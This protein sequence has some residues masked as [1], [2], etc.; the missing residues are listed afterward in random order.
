MGILE[1]TLAAAGLVLIVLLVIG[2]LTTKA[3]A[4]PTDDLAAPYRQGLH[5][6]IRMQVVAQ[7]LEQQLYSQAAQHLDDAGE[8]QPDHPGGRTPGTTA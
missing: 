2:A 5:A 1:A 7:D 4:P 3:P 8:R 6:A